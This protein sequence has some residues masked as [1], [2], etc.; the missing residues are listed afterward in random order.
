MTMDMSRTAN[1]ADAATRT[2]VRYAILLLIFLITTLNYADRATLSV[3]GSAMRT[4]FS[5]DAIRMGYIFSAFSWA[6]V[7][8]QL[9]AGWLLDRFGARRV[10]AASI[11]LWS[12]FTLLQSSIGLLGSAGAAVTALFVLRFAMGA[13]ESPAFPANA[14]VVASW[15][16]TNERGTASAIFNAAQYFAAVVFTPLMAWLTHA[17]G[18]QAVYVVMGALGLVL[19]LT[20]LKV[21]KNPADHPR[22]SAAELEYIQ[23]GGGVVTGHQ[24]TRPGNIENAGG[25]SLVRQLLGNRMLVGVYL[26]QYCIN[27]LT[28]FF[29][30]WFPIYLVQARGMTIL[31]AGLVA[32]L[33]AIC[34]FSGGVLGGVLSDGLIRRGCSLTVARKVP[35][36]GGMLLSVSIIGCN[37]VSTDWIVVALMSLAFFGKGIGALG[38]AVVADT[39]PK[40]ALGLSGGIFNMFGNVAGIVTPIVIGYLVARTGSF[41]GALVFVGANALLTVFSYLVIVKEIKRVELRPA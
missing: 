35:I 34:G 33:P 2:K 20:W 18:W 6:Y 21:M 8:S 3:T 25:W 14:K 36:V 22:V 37:Y 19:A 17:F 9:P 16:P 30:T 27:V 29:L 26:A 5:L 32:S 24:R 13:A 12:V 1:P 28:Y 31:H 10:Y 11:F 7:L 40:E 38:W 4:A 15:F 23:S 39:S 41:N